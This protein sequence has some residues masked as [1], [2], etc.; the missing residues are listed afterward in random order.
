VKTPWIP[1][2]AEGFRR[3]RE[4]QGKIVE[5]WLFVTN[6]ISGLFLSAADFSQALFTFLRPHLAMGL[7]EGHRIRVTV[8]RLGK[9][10][11]RRIEGQHQLRWGVGRSV[12]QRETEKFQI[13]VAMLYIR[14]FAEEQ[15]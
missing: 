11:R 1:V 5:D 3:S 6:A 8:E 14:I 13:D 9:W 4:S 10:V 15:V 7:S 12:W 2:V